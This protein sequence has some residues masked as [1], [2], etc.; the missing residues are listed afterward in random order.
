ML[1]D[2]I[3]A[4]RL[5]AINL[6]AAMELFNESIMQR[7]DGGGGGDD[8]DDDDDAD[9]VMV[10]SVKVNLDARMLLLTIESM[11][12]KSNKEITFLQDMGVVLSLPPTLPLRPADSIEQE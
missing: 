3:A 2:A 6:A 10:L 1:D 11:K 7:L 5:A 9:L 4:E 12:L 8:D